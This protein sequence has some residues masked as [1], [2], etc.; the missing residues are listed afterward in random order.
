MWSDEESATKSAKVSSNRDSTRAQGTAH[1]CTVGT[2]SCVAQQLRAAD[3]YALA[4]MWRFDTLHTKPT[5]FWL[6]ACSKEFW[7]K[8]LAGTVWRGLGPAAAKPTGEPVR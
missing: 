3:E 6:R 2:V 5:T 7:R 8:S 1:A 4:S